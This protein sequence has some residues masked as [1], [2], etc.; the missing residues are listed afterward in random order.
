MVEE[1]DDK[2]LCGNGDFPSRYTS[3]HCWDNREAVWIMI[4]PSPSPPRCSFSLVETIKM[5]GRILL[6]N[7]KLW[8][9]F[10]GRNF[11]ENGDGKEDKRI[12]ILSKETMSFGRHSLGSKCPKKS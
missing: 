10:L 6:G 12:Q 1:A 11:D 3:R 2:A 7:L 5:L 8:N 4:G 9:F